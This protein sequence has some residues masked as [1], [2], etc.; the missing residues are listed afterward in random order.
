MFSKL[1]Y[2]NI[3]YVNKHEVGSGSVENHYSEITIKRCEKNLFKYET[4][5][6]VSERS[7]L[8][9]YYYFGDFNREEKKD[10]YIKKFYYSKNDKLNI[11]L[12][13]KYE[14]ICEDRIGYKYFFYSFFFDLIE[15]KDTL[16][17]LQYL[18][19]IIDKNS[20]SNVNILINN[21]KYFL[22]LRGFSL[23]VK[24]ECISKEDLFAIISNL[25]K[26]SLIESLKIEVVNIYL[27]KDEEK[28]ILN[29]IEGIKMQKKAKK[30]LIELNSEIFKNFFERIPNKLKK[31]NKMIK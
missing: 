18:G 4:Q 3:L 14:E 10:L 20:Y 27:S 13:E 28:N 17:Y 9:N 15:K 1:N 11:N 5:K 30:I 21:L 19:I 29:C 16:K 7:G 25:S 8:N 24:D 12:I 23:V 31:L 6:Y 2:C 26:L 22:F